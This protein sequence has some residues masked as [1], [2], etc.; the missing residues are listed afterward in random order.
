[1]WFQRLLG[2][3]LKKKKKAE[4][5]IKGSNYKALNDKTLH[6]ELHTTWKKLSA[7]IILS[8]H[9]MTQSLGP[10]CPSHPWD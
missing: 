7:I 8:A 10:G 9:K 4:I 3:T 1:M 5:S 2:V 6:D